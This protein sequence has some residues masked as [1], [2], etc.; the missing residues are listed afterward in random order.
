MLP[1]SRSE[2]LREIVLLVQPVMAKGN[3]WETAK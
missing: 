3:L 2:Q 1:L